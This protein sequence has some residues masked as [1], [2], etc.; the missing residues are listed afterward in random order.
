MSTLGHNWIVGERQT[1]G[2]IFCIQNYH[3]LILDEVFGIT[4]RV[5]GE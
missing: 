4:E 1:L 3:D 2:A 5:C